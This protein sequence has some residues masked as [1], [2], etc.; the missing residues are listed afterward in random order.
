MCVDG[1]N[2]YKSPSHGFQWLHVRNI[3]YRDD[4]GDVWAKSSA[5]E[6]E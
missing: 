3:C 6:T 2:D 4:T 1:A 5:K